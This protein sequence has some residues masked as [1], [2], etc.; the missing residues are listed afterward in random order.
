MLKT[1]SGSNDGLHVK[2]FKEGEIYELSE[3]LSESFIST[4]VAVEVKH[5]K[6]KQVHSDKSNSDSDYQNKS[7]KPKAKKKGDE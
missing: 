7:D 6:E 5:E 3:S 1:S 2:E 4:G